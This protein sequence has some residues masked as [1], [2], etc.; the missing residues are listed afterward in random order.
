MEQTILKLKKLACEKGTEGTAY[1]GKY[2][3]EFKP[4]YYSEGV[5]RLVLVQELNSSIYND[6]LVEFKMIGDKVKIVGYVNDCY[7]MYCTKEDKGFAEESKRF[8]TA[9]C[10]KIEEALV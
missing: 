7:G 1:I 6:L 5:D 8:A 2:T 3:V 4:N 10:K 9:W